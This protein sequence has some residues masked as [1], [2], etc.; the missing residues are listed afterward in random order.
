LY[1]DRRRSFGAIAATNPIIGVVNFIVL[2][3]PLGWG[4]AALDYP[5]TV[6]RILKIKNIRW[7]AEG[8]AKSKVVAPRAVAY[9]YITV[10][11]GR[12]V[13]ALENPFTVNGHEAFYSFGKV[14]RGLIKKRLFDNIKISFYCD[15]TNRTINIDMTGINLLE[16]KGEL[17][18]ALRTSI[19]H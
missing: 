11:E 8:E 7:V 19:C 6:D 16:F 9:I 2:N 13:K 1:V 5:P 14:K 18:D 17:I 12:K 10:R 3:L 15:V 4:L